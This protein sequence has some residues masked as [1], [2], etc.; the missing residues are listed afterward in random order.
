MFSC[1]Y[2][3]F[4]NCQSQFSLTLGISNSDYLMW[5]PRKKCYPSK[6]LL[7]LLFNDKPT[8]QPSLPRRPPSVQCHLP[9]FPPTGWLRTKVL[10]EQGQYWAVFK[11]QPLESL[12]LNL[13]LLSLTWIILGQVASFFWA[14]LFSSVI[15]ISESQPQ[16]EVFSFQ[17]MAYLPPSCSRPIQGSFLIPPFLCPLQIT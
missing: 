4:V 16:R 1:N 2:W 13:L 17:L 6:L 5:F 15:W 14:R 12:A 7:S 3:A 10:P 8:H 9:W 11:I